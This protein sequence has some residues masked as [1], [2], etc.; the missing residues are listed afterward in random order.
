[1]AEILKLTRAGASDLN[2]LGGTDGIELK[3][4][5]AWVQR[6]HTPVYGRQPALVTESITVYVKDDSNDELS[7]ILQDIA[8][9][10]RYVAQYRSDKTV[11]IPV[12]LYDQMVNETNPRRAY[13]DALRFDQTESHHD[14]DSNDSY[15]EGVLSLL[16]G[17]WEAPTA[18]DLPQAIP[19]A[20]RVDNVTTAFTPGETITGAA[21]GDTGVVA[22]S[23][24]SGGSGIV[25]F[26]DTSGAFQNNEQLDGSVGGANM[27]LA[28]GTRRS[29][30]ALFY[31]YTAA[32]DAVA[33]H[34]I[35]GDI[36]ARI[37]H[38]AFSTPLFGL[39]RM[40]LGLRSANKYGA[41]RMNNLLIIWECEKG[42]LGVN[43]SLAADANA[44]P[45]GAGNTKVTITTDTTW[46]KR[47]TLALN[48]LTTDE[49][50]QVGQFLKLLRAQTGSGDTWEVQ[51]RHNSATATIDRS[52]GPIF[53]VSGAGYAIHEAGAFTFPSNSD[54]HS[55]SAF[56]PV[57]DSETIEIWARQ[58]GGT[59]NLDLDCIVPLPV[60][61]GW[62]IA[63]DINIPAGGYGF[64][65][66]E[67]PDGARFTYSGQSGV[68]GRLDIPTINAYMQLPP[69]D[70]R[71]VAAWTH[72]TKF[73]NFV[74]NLSFNFEDDG[75][76]L[77]RWRLL[78][79]AE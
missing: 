3:D 64:I 5:N 71:I 57:P 74:N 29:A 35:V 69:G 4:K 34:D 32:G 49:D 28:D 18:R 53:E 21:S 61:E 26:Y 20:L 48:Q 23:A 52:T 6:S 78:R 72:A 12:Y 40:Y 73:Q 42:T 45:E 44:S 46:Q 63:C 15:L 68:F 10:E 77:E 1:M 66:G 11:E 59:G 31:D 14:P 24:I 47:L 65:F 60:D 2:I 33:A 79:G 19:G 7:T 38:C 8:E 39:D 36:E 27:A 25:Y 9:Y 56:A 13:V 54:R 58:T 17:P 67:D 51:L 30:P 16:R 62:M 70:G 22:W 41:D 75:K 50:D 76:Y 43:A 55:Q 37:A